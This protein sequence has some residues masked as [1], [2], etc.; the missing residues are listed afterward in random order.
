MGHSGRG[1]QEAVVEAVSGWRVCSSEGS[2]VV[3]LCVRPD[4][5]GKT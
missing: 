3:P 4:P 1:G 2:R 5:D